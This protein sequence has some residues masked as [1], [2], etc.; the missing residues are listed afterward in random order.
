MFGTYN[1]ASTIMRRAFDWKRI[2]TVLIHLCIRNVRKNSI[3]YS[4]ALTILFSL[5]GFLNSFIASY[6]S[7]AVIVA[8]IIHPPYQKLTLLV[9][10]ATICELTA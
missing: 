9:N 2:E 1:G 5:P 3:A 6:L 8:N 4:R 10:V 7:A